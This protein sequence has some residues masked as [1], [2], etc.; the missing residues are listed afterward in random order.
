[1]GAGPVMHW[2]TQRLGCL[3]VCVSLPLKP[4]PQVRLLKVD[5]GDHAAPFIGLVR[6]DSW[7]WRVKGT[8]HMAPET[9]TKCARAR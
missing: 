4:Y 9:S 6:I 1:M 5:L 7:T 2:P 8:E 3:A